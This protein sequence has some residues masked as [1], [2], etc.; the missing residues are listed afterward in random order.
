MSKVSLLDTALSMLTYLAA[1]NLNKGLEPVK[2][3]NSSHQTI[4]PAQNFKTK[5]GY[6]VVFCAKEKF[7]QNLCEVLEV[8]NLARDPRCASFEARL[9]NREFVV[10]GVAELF[11]NRTTDEWLRLLRGKVPAARVNRMGEALRDPQVVRD[12]IVETDHPVFGKVKQ[13]GSPIRIG[14]RT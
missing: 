11:R 5:D 10:T 1:W 4:I 14:P 2:T 8:P 3:E 13:I 7:W 12:M 6:I 9:K